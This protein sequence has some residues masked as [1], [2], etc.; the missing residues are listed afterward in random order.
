M[1][2]SGS[3]RQPRSAPISGRCRARSSRGPFQSGEVDING[4]LLKRGDKMLR[5]LLDEAANSILGRLKRDCG[6]RRWGLALQER[7]GA[8]CA[9]VAVARK[10][11]AL[12]H[13]RWQHNEEFRWQT[14]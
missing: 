4:A 12:L 11:A 3:P 8:K 13:R 6:L 14:V 5:H 1:I 10:L 2:R 7:V 9:R